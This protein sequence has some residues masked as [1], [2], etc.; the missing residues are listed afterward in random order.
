MLEQRALFP[1]AFCRECGQQ[2]L[3]RQPH[4]RTGTISYAPRRERDAS[5]GE[6]ANGYLFLCGENPW[7]VDPVTEGRL[8]DSWVTT[9][10]DGYAEALRHAAV[11][12]ARVDVQPDGTESPTAGGS[13]S[14]GASP[15]LSSSAAA[16]PM[17]RHAASESGSSPPSTRREQRCHFLALS[18]APRAACELRCR[19][20]PPPEARKLLT[21][22]DNRQ[23]ASL[24]AGHFNDFVQVVQ[25]RGA[26]YPAAA[27]EPGG[28]RHETV[29]QRV[30]AALD[31]EFAEFA[32]NPGI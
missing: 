4:V 2:Y 10:D 27:A 24:Q 20:G 17:S 31:L 25:L 30:T 14:A 8:P 26:L 29:A 13:G 16:F 3:R 7:P 15:F 23:D 9:D 18:P 19:R 5:G 21:F 11:S 12:A 28:L 32:A 22:V 1:L 6:A